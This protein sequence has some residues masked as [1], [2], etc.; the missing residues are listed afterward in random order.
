[1]IGREILIIVARKT[2]KLTINITK[3]KRNKICVRIDHRL[4]F[5]FFISQERFIP[6][7]RKRLRQKH[8]L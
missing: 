8:K 1:M 7:S 4:I 2:F 5:V 6:L 3:L